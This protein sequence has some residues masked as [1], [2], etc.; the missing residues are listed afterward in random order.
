MPKLYL[1]FY[2]LTS[3]IIL[4]YKKSPASRQKAG[5]VKMVMEM[6]DRCQVSS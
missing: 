4:I 2:L 3:I 1:I 5:Q 6:G